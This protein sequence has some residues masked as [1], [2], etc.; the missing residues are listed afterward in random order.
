MG[1][2]VVGAEIGAIDVDEVSTE[3]GAGLLGLDD[4]DELV[5]PAVPRTLATSRLLTTRAALM[6]QRCELS[7]LI[8][9]ISVAD[10]KR[11]EVQIQG[12]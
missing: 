11:A 3:L 9:A 8:T 2:I 5:Q 10:R 7:R 12:G 1:A 6:V 4:F